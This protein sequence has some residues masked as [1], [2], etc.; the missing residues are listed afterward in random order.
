MDPSS[1]QGG[2]LLGPVSGGNV[3][4]MEIRGRRDAAVGAPQQY[5]TDSGDLAARG[6]ARGMGVHKKTERGV[7]GVEYIPLW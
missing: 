1:V 3:L 7:G 4:N 5:K 6:M 2:S